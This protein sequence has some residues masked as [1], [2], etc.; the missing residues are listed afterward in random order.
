M[1][2]LKEKEESLLIE[3]INIISDPNITVFGYFK[4]KIDNNKDIID[5]LKSL[6]D[7]G[8]IKIDN[9]EEYPINIELTD[10]GKNYFKDKEIDI[11]KVKIG[12]RKIKNKTI[13]LCF[14]SLICGI[15][16]GILMYHFMIL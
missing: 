16:I 7:N 6:E 2:I 1:N 11:Q 3:I 4:E 13:S 15:I 14:I 8:L 12:K 5:T 10:L 9:M